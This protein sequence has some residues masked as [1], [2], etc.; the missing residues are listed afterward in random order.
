M[1]ILAGINVL[2]IIQGL[3]SCKHKLGLHPKKISDIVTF[4]MLAFMSLGTAIVYC[5]SEF[6]QKRLESQRCSYFLIESLPA[7]LYLLSA[8]AYMA[9]SISSLML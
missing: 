1:A 7:I 6:M 3:I 4:Y 2:V 8:Y 5:L 9:Q